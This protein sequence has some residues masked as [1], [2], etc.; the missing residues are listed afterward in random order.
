[1]TLN[2]KR[3]YGLIKFAP[4]GVIGQAAH[5]A[6]DIWKA[7]LGAT[8]RTGGEW[9]LVVSNPEY[10]VYRNTARMIRKAK[11]LR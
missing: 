11:R 9:D 7:E 4:N 10:K 3:K 8:L 6:V 2:K 5:E 1:M